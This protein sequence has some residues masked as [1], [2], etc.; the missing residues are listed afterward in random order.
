MLRIEPIKEDQAPSAILELVDGPKEMRFAFTAWTIARMRAK[1][2][3]ENQDFKINDM[4]AHNVMKVTRY[5]KNG[6][7]DL[8][9]MVQKF[10]RLLAEGD[11]GVDD[12]QK[13]RVY[14]EQTRSR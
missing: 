9:D 6:E 12:V 13:R 2:E 5:R 4:T 14:P 11:D 1:A 3:E 8:E 10:E 7:Q